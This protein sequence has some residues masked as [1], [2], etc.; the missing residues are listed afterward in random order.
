MSWN[1]RKG[2]GS[3][4]AR[5]SKGLGEMRSELVCEISGRPFQAEATARA[6]DLKPEEARR[7]VWL[8]PSG[9]ESERR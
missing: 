4:E 8:E 3:L 2:W 5:G 1:W 6:N 7:P 9:S